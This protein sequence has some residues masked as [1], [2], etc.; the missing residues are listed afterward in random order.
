M[1]KILLDLSITI[2]YNLCIFLIGLVLCCIFLRIDFLHNMIYIFYFRMMTYAILSALIIVIVAL[3]LVSKRT[4]KIFKFLD[5][6]MI[7][8][9]FAISFLLIFSF[10]GMTTFTCDRSYT[11]FSL[12]YLYENANKSYTQ[13]EME[14]IFIDGFVKNFGATKKRIAE[15]MNTGYI[16]EKDGRYYISESGKRFIELC[17]QI[18]FFFPTATN[19]SSL[20][21][22]GNN[23]RKIIKN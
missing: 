19:P 17:R 12:G 20:Y 1:K 21:P 8:S 23:N 5:N 2:L 22:N 15:Q 14:E 11:I 6:K 16:K 3:V 13:E 7:F 9:G 10:L 18:D 4:A